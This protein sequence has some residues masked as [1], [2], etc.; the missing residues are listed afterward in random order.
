M[1]SR[2]VVDLF[3]AMEFV[4]GVSITDYCDRFHL[5]VPER[6]SLFL[7]LC[8]AIEYA[9]EQGIV[10]RDLKPSNLLVVRRAGDA[11][12]KVIDFELPSR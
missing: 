1:G 12:P 6:L 11:M 5:S 2:S 4:N 9:H 3:F 7:K 8:R 10:H